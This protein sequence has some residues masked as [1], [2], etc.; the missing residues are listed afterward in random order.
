MGKR[1]KRIRKMNRKRKE[2]KLKNERKNALFKLTIGKD[3]SL[4]SK[5]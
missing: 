3:S 1:G 4:E 2:S 5:L